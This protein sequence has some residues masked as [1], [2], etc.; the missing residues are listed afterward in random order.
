[1]SQEFAIRFRGVCKNYLR[2]S[3]DGIQSRIPVWKRILAGGLLPAY[4][5]A[6]F[7][8]LDGVSFDIRKGERVAL[9]GSNGAGKSTI[10][11]L[12]ARVVRPTSGEIRTRGRV[13]SLLEVGA[14][15]HPDLTGREN[16]E[17][18]GAILGIPK[19]LM[20]E[21]FPK[22]VEFAE[23]G[24]FLDTPVKRYS[25]GMYLRLAFAVASHVEA[26]IMLVDEALAVGD[27][28]FQKKCFTKIRSLHSSGA[29]LVFVS[30]NQETI[31]DLCDRGITLDRGKI[32]HDAPIR[33]AVEFYTQLLHG[34][35]N[36]EG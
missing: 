7:K 22:I 33:E 12:I 27:L 29:T 25:S 16:V 18:S 14:G 11:K 8:A 5:I 17:L 36:E 32:V 2:R 26:E 4:A 19:N 6:E 35:L 9:L 13:G 10:L 15:F 21:A 30:H 1:M 28:N 24:E 34:G 31:L 23:I 20:K 3:E